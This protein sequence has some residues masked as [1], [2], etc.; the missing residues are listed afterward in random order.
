MCVHII[1]LNASGWSAVY[2]FMFARVLWVLCQPAV[3]GSAA[4]TLWVV[5][6][7]VHP[8]P[9]PPP[10]PAPPA[11]SYERAR[12]RASYV[13]TYTAPHCAPVPRDRHSR[14]IASERLDALNASS[15]RVHNSIVNVLHAHPFFWCL[16]SSSMH[17]LR[18]CDATRIEIAKCLH[19]E[20]IKR[21]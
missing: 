7:E 1:A 14:L 21:L 4:S 17:T 15:R 2:M 10:P 8:P 13:I 11:T 5:I 16:P 3:D 18:R 6:C 19:P 12:A 9:P 20:R